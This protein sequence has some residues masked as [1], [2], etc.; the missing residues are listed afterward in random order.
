MEISEQTK[1][2]VDWL[3]CNCTCLSPMNDVEDVMRF[4]R[5]SLAEGK[6]QGFTPLLI[7]GE[8]QI[9]EQTIIENI[10]SDAYGFGQVNPEQTLKFRTVMLSATLRD[11]RE[12]LDGMYDE[13]RRERVEYDPEWVRNILGTMEGGTA[14]N[15]FCSVWDPMSGMTHP[16]IL[17]RIPVKDPWRVFAWVP[18]GGWNDC[19]GTE[20]TMAAAKYWF[21]QYGAVP[22]VIT[23]D[24]MDLILPK[25]VPK[26][27]ALQTAYELFGFCPDLVEQGPAY[28]TIGKLADI[29]GKSTVWSFWWD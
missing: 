15:Q 19:P 21:E 27:K 2:F 12:V 5:Q 9:L 26:E 8:D 18:A 22:A 11:G 7:A 25:P 20:D 3:G 17:A 1:A 13:R 14:E 10:G 28:P 23:G 16:L 29:I 24:G 4:Y 6:E